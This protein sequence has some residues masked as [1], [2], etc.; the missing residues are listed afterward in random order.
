V[1][2][3]NGSEPDA[4]RR[5]LSWARAAGFEDVTSSASTWCYA[6]AEDRRWWSDTWAERITNTQ[7]ADQAVER[8]FATRDELD[9]IAIAWRAWADEPDGWFAVL[10]GEILCRA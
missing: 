1:H 8:R 2:R 3:G 5:L 6:S 10:H 4:G 7:L 9:E